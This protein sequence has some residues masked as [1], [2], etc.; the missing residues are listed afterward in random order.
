[1]DTLFEN[2]EEAGRQLAEKL[3]SYAGKD[4]VVLGLPR[5]GVVVAQAISLAL[6]APLDITVPRKIGAPQNPE[7]ALGAITEDGEHVFEP[8]IMD[9]Y[10]SEGLEKKIEEEQKEAQRRL[11]VYRAGKPGLPLQGKTVLVV[12][13]G[14]ATGATMRAALLSVRKKGAKKV[15]VAV[16]VL[17][18]DSVNRFQKEAD[19]LVYLFAPADFGAVGRFYRFFPQTTDEEVIRIMKET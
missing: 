11:S 13:D 6:K 8:Y 14:I 18:Q 10:T 9:F 15:I 1:M 2:R 19:A 3:R 5:G 4:T 16:P 17:P 12:D 7:W